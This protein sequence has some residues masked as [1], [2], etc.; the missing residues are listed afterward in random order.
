M[1]RSGHSYPAKALSAADARGFFEHAG[2][3]I[4][5]SSPTVIRPLSERLQRG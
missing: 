5:Q 3:P 1:P 2:Y 4:R